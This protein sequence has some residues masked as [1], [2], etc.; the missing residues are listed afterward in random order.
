[1]S[2]YS[3]HLPTPAAPAGRAARPFSW[4][5]ALARYARRRREEL[6]LSLERAAQ[7]AGLELSE[8]YALE[9]GWV[10]DLDDMGRI[11]AIAAT[12]EVGWMDFSVL[13]LMAQFQQGPPPEKESD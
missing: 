3:H 2:M 8:W 1:M 10:P 7:L 4:P 12:L 11:Q 13:L 9:S 5:L 6:D